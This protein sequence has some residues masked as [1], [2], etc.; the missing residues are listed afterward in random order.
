[1]GAIIEWVFDSLN[2]LEAIAGQVGR[3]GTAD[4]TGVLKLYESVPDI[5]GLIANPN[6]AYIPNDPAIL[7][8]VCAAIA[9]RVNDKNIGNVV[10][11]LERL[12]Q[13]EFSAFVIKDAINRNKELKQS[14][15]IRDWIRNTG[16]N[17]R[18]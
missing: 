11:Y 15:V 7:Y 1:M 4:C 3:A 16:K 2:Q 17:L 10:K 6:S 9:S 13:Q 14:Q 12:P 5:Y 18:L 8:A